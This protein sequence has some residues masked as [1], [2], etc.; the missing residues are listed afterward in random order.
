MQQLGLTILKWYQTIPRSTIDNAKY[1]AF[2]LHCSNSR[3]WWKHFPGNSFQ[4]NAITQNASEEFVE[5][6]TNIN[7]GNL[8]TIRPS[9]ITWVIKSYFLFIN[10]TKDIWQFIKFLKQV[11]NEDSLVRPNRWFL[12]PK[13]LLF[14]CYQLHFFLL[15]SFSSFSRHRHLTLEARGFQ[16]W[17]WERETHFLRFWW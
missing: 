13:S 5:L 3:R 14:T 16:N 6:R 15:C 7:L 9:L 2:R 4:N 17:S 11:E 1:L 8:S 12:F 10:T